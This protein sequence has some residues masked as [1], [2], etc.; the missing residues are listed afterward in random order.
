MS[1]LCLG[2]MLSP[3]F[4]CDLMHVVH[5][6]SICCLWGLDVSFS[7]SDCQLP[8]FQLVLNREPSSDFH[9]LPKFANCFKMVFIK[10][11][12]R[13]IINPGFNMRDLSTE[14]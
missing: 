7:R 1:K 12:L 4:P 8:G 2:A 5:V 6:S 14:D 11:A 13:S 10:L 3:C 9:V